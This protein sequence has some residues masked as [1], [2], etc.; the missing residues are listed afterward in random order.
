MNKKDTKVKNKNG[1]TKK[2]NWIVKKERNNGITLIALVITIIVLLILAGVTIASITGENGI[3]SKATNARDNN[4]KASAEEKVKTEV[5]G[6]YGSDGKLSLDDLNNNLKNVDGLKYN[7]S[8]ISA[9]NKIESLPATVNVDGYDVVITEQGNV[10]KPK[11]LEDAKTDDMLT[12]TDDTPITVDNKIV[13]IPAGFK[14]ADDSGN[15]IDE[16]IVIEDSEKNQFVWVPVSKENFATEFVRREGYMNGSLQSY[17]SDCG[18][19]DATGKNKRVKE[20]ETTKQEAKNMYASVERNEGFYIARYE[21]GK[22]GE[23]VVSKKGADVYN[24][25]PWSSNGEMQ[26]TTGTTGGAVELSRNFANAKNYKTVTSTL[27]YG[28]QWDAVMKWME[29]VNN[30]NI[31]GKTYIQDSTGMGW[32]SDNYNSGN[33]DHKTGI[34]IG[35][36]NKGSNQVKKIY[37]LAGNVYEWTMESCYTNSRV[38]RGGGYVLTGSR[39]PAS[40]RD[41]GFYF[42]SNSVVNPRFSPHFILE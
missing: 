23:N 32:Y 13:K 29:N 30:P 26:E 34:D 21:A 7:G 16:G 39:R 6:S 10:E 38:H 25:I 3:L 37:D 11:T 20:T 2:K 33:S 40:D 35:E 27:I 12:K 24:E 19:A 8:A 41:F 42:L 4:T 9:S 36:E 17:L 5:L 28:V 22:E 18:E 1:G 31:E 14:V 15:T